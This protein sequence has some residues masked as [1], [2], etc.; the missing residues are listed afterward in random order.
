MNSV[1]RYKT[2]HKP[3]ATFLLGGTGR[4]VAQTRIATA[5]YISL[6]CFA[7]WYEYTFYA[8]QPRG[9]IV[10]VMRNPMALV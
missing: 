4:R 5:T 3:C 6:Q 7:L 1:D 2:G 10:Y 9:R 8:T